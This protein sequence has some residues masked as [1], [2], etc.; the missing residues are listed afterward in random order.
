LAFDQAEQLRQVRRVL[1]ALSDQSREGMTGLTSRRKTQGRVALYR[2]VINDKFV[3]VV[4]VRNGH[5]NPP[6]E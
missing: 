2:I 6:L 3:A 1:A 5:N 4:R